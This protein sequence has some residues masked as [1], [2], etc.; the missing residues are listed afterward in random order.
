MELCSLELEAVV[1]LSSPEWEVVVEWKLSGLEL[2]VP[3]EL[4]LCWSSLEL[5]HCESPDPCSLWSGLVGCV[6]CGCEGCLW[7]MLKMMV[8]WMR[9]LGSG[10]C[11]SLAWMNLDDCVVW[12]R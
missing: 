3:V 4:K 1:E 8:G 6:G 2:V 9:M 10:V 5:G 7:L 12:L 11:Y